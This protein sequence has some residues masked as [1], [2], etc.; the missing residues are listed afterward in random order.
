MNA[1]SEPQWQQLLEFEINVCDLPRATRLSL[2]LY[3]VDKSKKGK[4]TKKRSKKV[5]V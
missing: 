4:S 2:A 5:G 1:S 3:A